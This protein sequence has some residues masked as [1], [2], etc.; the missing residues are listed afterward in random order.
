MLFSGEYSDFLLEKRKTRWRPWKP[1][2]HE[3]EVK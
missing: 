2:G 3:N 1:V